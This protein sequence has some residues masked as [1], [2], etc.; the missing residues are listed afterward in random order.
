MVERLAEL[1]R[2]AT[3]GALVQDPLTLRAHVLLDLVRDSC[4]LPERVGDHRSMLM[5]A[6]GSD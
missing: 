2:G 4:A 5:R 3:N 6:A 1:G